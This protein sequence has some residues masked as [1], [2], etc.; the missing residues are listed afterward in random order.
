MIAEVQATA[1]ALNIDRGL[2]LHGRISAPYPL[3]DGTNRVLLSYRPCEVTKNGVVVSC[4]TLTA[5][6]MARLPASWRSAGQALNTGSCSPAS[7][8]TASRFCAG[9]SGHGAKAV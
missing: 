9:G 5:D 1:Q 8:A 4:T 2:S 3:W 6:E 7:T